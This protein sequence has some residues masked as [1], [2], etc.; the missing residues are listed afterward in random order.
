MV[1]TLERELELITVPII[2]SYTES[3][4]SQRQKGKSGHEDGTSG[5]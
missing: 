2:E 3:K 4:Q 5:K 1:F